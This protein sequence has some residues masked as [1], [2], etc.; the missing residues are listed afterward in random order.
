MTTL[1]AVL[2]DLRDGLLVESVSATVVWVNAAF[3][4]AV[5]V[6][7]PPERWTGASRDDFLR[8]ATELDNGDAFASEAISGADMQRPDG[9]VLR[10]LLLPSAH[11]RVW[12][13]RATQPEEAEDP[14]SEHAA[15]PAGTGDGRVL[16]V[17]DNAVN[18]ILLLRMLEVLDVPA[19]AANNGLEGLAA[20]RRHHYDLV[21][22]DVGMPVL[23]GLDATRTLRAEETGE[24]RTPVVAL[25]A[26]TTPED[27][28]RC[29]EAGM[30]GFLPKPINLGA[31]REV[32]TRYVTAGDLTAVPALP[33]LDPTPL[34][35]LQ[36]QLGDDGLVRDAVLMYLG[37]LPGRIEQ[38]RG[39]IPRDRDGLKRHAHSLKSSS[40]ML[41]AQA[42]ARRCADLEAMSH[43]GAPDELG[44]ALS[45]VEELQ[46]RTA[47]AFGRWLTP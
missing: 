41:G 38:I 32:L 42:L 30:D 13:V 36:E 25:S 8:A 2:G 15:V 14:G 7:G 27:R 46:G 34:T 9:R 39:A 24:R 11:G 18:R 35:D 33:V 4:D 5:G 17:E 26:A 28:R 3:C 31:L 45:A 1:A 20:V 22:M 10:L 6:P 47:D 16:V 23:D 21:L 12:L 40:A 44:R 29:E 37:E 19:D 43:T